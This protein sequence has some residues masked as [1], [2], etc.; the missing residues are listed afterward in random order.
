VTKLFAEPVPVTPEHM[1]YATDVCDACR[2]KF[3][4]SVTIAL[5]GDSGRALGVWENK[6]LLHFPLWLVKAHPSF[7]KACVLNYATRPVVFPFWMVLA[8]YHLGFCSWGCQEKAGQ[9]R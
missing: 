3:I 9:R 7:A 5:L 4:P 6:P 1:F 8:D 2:K